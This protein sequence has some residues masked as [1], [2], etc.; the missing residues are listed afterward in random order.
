M[1]RFNLTLEWEWA[2]AQA[3]DSNDSRTEELERWLHTY[4]YH[5][6]PMAHRET[7]HRCSEQRP[8]EAHLGDPTAG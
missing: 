4:N 3:Y 8:G 1:E 2:Y 5:R 7:A 6:P